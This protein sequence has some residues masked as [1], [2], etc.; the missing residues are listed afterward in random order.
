MTGED[1]SRDRSMDGDERDRLPVPSSTGSTTSAL[2]PALAYRDAPPH[3]QTQSSGTSIPPPS[4][5][6]F[7][8]APSAP[9]AS[10]SPVDRTTNL[11][12]VPPTGPK[13]PPSGPRGAWSATLEAAGA[14]EPVRT[15]LG[16]RERDGVNANAGAGAGAGVGGRARELSGASN[17]S[18]GSNGTVGRPVPVPLG[19]MRGGFRGGFEGGRGGW[20]GRGGF[21]GRGRGGW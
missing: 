11:P 5:N 9:R 17:A 8:H 16:G 13:V 12:R 19:G 6:N 14:I 20:R 4:R 18:N 3:S 10:L 7:A 21:G 15:D 1:R 2:P